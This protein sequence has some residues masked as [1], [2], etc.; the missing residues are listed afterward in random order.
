MKK[1]MAILW[2]L[3]VTVFNIHAQQATTKDSLV[4]QLSLSKEDSAMVKLLLDLA[5][6]YRSNV[7]DSAIKFYKQAAALSKKIG[8]GPGRIK[9]AAGIAYGFIKKGNY[10][11]SL[12]YYSH[13]DSLCLVLKQEELLLDI[14][15]PYSWV[16]NNQSRFDDALN[17]CKR[18]LDISL[19][20]KNKKD[21]GYAYAAIGLVYVNK[22]F[23]QQALENY[24]MA[25]E[26]FRSINDAA[27]MCSMYDRISGCYYSLKLY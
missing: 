27:A 23:F 13:A 9:A 7:P 26:N 24:F 12:V 5:N 22:S 10:D 1:I 14:F 17:L 18:T 6:E 4:K 25:L 15:S 21:V 11:S 3:P 2:L 20:R 16:L 19:R 8:Y